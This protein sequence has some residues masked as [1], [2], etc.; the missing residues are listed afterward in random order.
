MMTRPSDRNP[1]TKVPSSV[2]RIV[3]RPPVSA[4]PPITT[5]AIAVSS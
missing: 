2:L 1:I 5:A 4:A 3:L